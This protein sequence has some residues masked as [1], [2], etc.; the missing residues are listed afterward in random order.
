MTLDIAG[1][2]EERRLLRCGCA[3]GDGRGS[4]PVLRPAPRNPQ[5]RLA[6]LMPTFT[7]LA[8][9]NEQLGFDAPIAQAITGAHAGSCTEDDV[10]Y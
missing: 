3:A 2:P 6:V 5:G 7:Y 1:G 10:E 8:Y 9:A 4:H